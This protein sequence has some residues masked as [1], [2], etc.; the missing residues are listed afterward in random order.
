[1]YSGAIAG[2]IYA[3]LAPLAGKVTRVVL[4]GP[5]HRVYVTGAA[6][7]SSEAFASPLGAVAL[8]TAAIAK[9]RALPFVEVSDAGARARAFAGSAPALPAVG[10]GL[11]L[12]GA[13]RR[14]GCEPR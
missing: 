9:L 2:S 10:A 8:D 5:A 3:R 1:M 14:G 6:V 4:A 7:P 11:V 13:H 12:A